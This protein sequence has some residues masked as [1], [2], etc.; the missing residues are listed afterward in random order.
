LCRTG[1]DA[2]AAEVVVE[3]VANFGGVSNQVARK[4]VC[5]IGPH[6]A[7]YRHGKQRRSKPREKEAEEGAATESTA[8][9]LHSTE[10][11]DDSQAL[12]AFGRIE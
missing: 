12:S 3:C 2:R 7:I 4:R 10:T 11:D 1:A 8:F 5:K 9:V 6:V